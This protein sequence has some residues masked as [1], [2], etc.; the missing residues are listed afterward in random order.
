MRKSLALAAARDT[1][2]LYLKVLRVAWY[3]LIPLH[4]IDAGSNQLFA[5]ATDRMQAM[6]REDFFSLACM[7]VVELVFTIIWSAAWILVLTI[8]AQFVIGQ[9]QTLPHA[10]PFMQVLI[11]EIRV[12]GAILWR[13]PLLIVPAL[14]QYVRLAFVPFIVILDPAYARGEVDALAAS[15]RLSRGKF[16][17]L[18]A[19]VLISFTL[20]WIL[21]ELAQGDSG[22]I[23]SEPLKGVASTTLSLFINIASGLFLFSLYRLVS[24]TP[25]VREFAM[26]PTI[27]PA[28]DI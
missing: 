12:L 4:L 5:V 25:V 13:L 7:A 18:G 21:D 6:G 26:T 10:R 17:L 1:S 3:W 2:A 24:Q 27:V 16:L 11:E 22:S 20:P 15:R 28:K 23:W 14:F 8:S 19:T 9:R